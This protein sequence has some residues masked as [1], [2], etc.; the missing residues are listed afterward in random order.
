MGVVCQRRLKGIK[1]WG[2]IVAAETAYMLSVRIVRMG[3]I[4]S[5]HVLN[6]S[7]GVIK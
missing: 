2:E 1:K 6:Q 3:L 5:A 7:R 4:D